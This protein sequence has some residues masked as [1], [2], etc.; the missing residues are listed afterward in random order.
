[1][2]TRVPLLFCLIATSIV[3]PLT[4][5]AAP[6]TLSVQ[7]V[8][9]R[10][11][12]TSPLV[13]EVEA[14]IAA[15]RGSG[16]DLGRWS[17][18]TL[19]SEVRIPS[20]TDGA[21]DNNEVAVS[22]S[23]PMRISDFGLRQRI[24]GIIQ[25]AADVKRKMEVLEAAQSIRLAFV[26][27]WALENR[28]ASLIE[29][30][31]RASRYEALVKRGMENGLFGGGE[32]HLFRAEILSLRNRKRALQSDAARSR[33]ELQ[34]QAGF[35]IDAPLA[36]PPVGSLPAIG[37]LIKTNSS[38]PARARAELLV[39][40]AHA[41]QRLAR[42]DSAPTFAPRF[43]YERNSDAVNYFG[44][45]VSVDLPFFDRNQGERLQRHAEASAADRML[46]YM[47]GDGFTQQVT[48]LHGALSASLTSVRSTESE[49]LPALRE[50]LTAQERQLE[51]GQGSVFQ[52][53]QVLREVMHAEDEATSDF[54][55]AHADRAELATIIGQEI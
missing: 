46:V 22:L 2:L 41:Q 4:S 20:H 15:E 14:R 49:I 23:Q 30:E 48:A 34:R 21:N 50:A 32:S 54:L 25:D 26:K 53:W 6:Q 44:V 51:S 3:A 1:M 10:A 9:S 5:S 19:D 28:A 16:L 42:L 35:I 38:L 13:A 12:E 24:N 33:A 31:Q 36:K 40:L 39:K 45:G 55:R 7:E 47:S 52:V 11:L 17:N 37:E 27:T 8:L 29:S 43:V 18:P